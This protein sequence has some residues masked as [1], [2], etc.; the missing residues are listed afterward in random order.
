MKNWKKIK[1]N[2]EKNMCVSFEIMPKKKIMPLF[3]VQISPQFLIHNPW[4]VVHS[5]GS[6]ICGHFEHRVSPI[7]D[8]W[9]NEAVFRVFCSVC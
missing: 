9:S 7:S 6:N 5:P 3:I 1:V 8:I 2:I 4:P